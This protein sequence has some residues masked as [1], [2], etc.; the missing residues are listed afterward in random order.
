MLTTGHTKNG[1]SPVIDLPNLAQRPRPAETQMAEPQ[2][3]LRHAIESAR[4][5]YEALEARTLE[6]QKQIRREEH[7]VTQHRR[8]IQELEDQLARWRP[9]LSEAEARL[10]S[11]RQEFEN[12]ARR[13]RDGR[14]S[15]PG[16][17]LP[18]RSSERAA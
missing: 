4:S 1:L 7:T 13:A 2:E 14:E 6:L 9:I 8:K 16:S 15:R 3:T 11:V 12:L 5:S 10:D 17:D 18:R